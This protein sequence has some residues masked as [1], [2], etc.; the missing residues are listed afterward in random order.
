MCG[1]VGTFNLSADPEVPRTAIEAAV[2]RMRLRGPDGKGMHVRPG[3]GFGHRRLSIIDLDGGAQPFVDDATGVA[4]TFNGEIYNYLEL[5]R[6]LQERGHHFR[7][8]SD[9]EVL[10]RSYLEWGVSTPS[11]LVGMFA[12][13]IHDPRSQALL[14]ARDRLG[15]KPLF[16]SLEGGRVSFASSVAAMRML[17]GIGAQVDLRAVSHYLTTV[18]TTLGRRT[19]LRDVQTLLPGETLVARR[20]DADVRIERYWDI[21]VVPEAD[22]ETVDFESACEQVRDLVEASVGD[23]LMSDVPLGGFLSGGVDSAV[24]AS[25]AA[26]RSAGDYQAYSVGF[27]REGYH[28]WPQIRAT[29]GH[30]G[31]GHVE[32]ELDEATYGTEWRWLIAEKGMPLSTPNEVGILGLARALRQRCTVALSGEGAD[33]VFGGY[34]IPYFSA[35]DLERSRNGRSPALVEALTRLYGRDRFDSR[36]DHF[37]SLNSWTPLPFKPLLLQGAVWEVMER[38]RWMLDHYRTMLG[39]LED[40]TT[41]DAYLHLHAHVNLEG[42]LSRVDSSTMAA[43]VETRVPFTDHRLVEL[44]FRLPD[45]YKI[46]WR[47]PAA[48][49]R[50]ADLNVVEIDGDDLLASKRLLRRAFRTHLPEEVLERRKMSFPTPFLEA[51]SGELA[52]LVTSTVHDSGLGRDLFRPEGLCAVLGSDGAEPQ[53]PVWPVA[54]LCLWAEECGAKV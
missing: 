52:E 28:E 25:V 48:R 9:T 37:F 42:L 17:P 54:N 1:I 34:T 12:F 33:E 4:L 18:R 36:L 16:Y 38:D 21:P 5:R 46:D 40:C 26:P 51:F 32:I 44:L 7:S 22:K 27:E 11:R 20:S 14:L 35:H 49:A 23:R 10:L 30:L 29:A 24:I 6:M 15:V 41:F 19:L 39:R 50:G 31:I 45:T 13:A 8:R 2:E 47:S 53:L 3:V 43:S